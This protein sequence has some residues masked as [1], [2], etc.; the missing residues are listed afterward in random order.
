M[1]PLD[2]DDYN[3]LMKYSNELLG[4]IKENQEQI[5]ALAKEIEDLKEELKRKTDEYSVFN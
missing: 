4:L 1:R 5:A 2:V 3:E